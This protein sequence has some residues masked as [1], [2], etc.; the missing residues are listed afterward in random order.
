MIDVVVTLA[1]DADSTNA[2]Q[3]DSLDLSDLELTVTQN[4][5]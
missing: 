4:P 1:F 5:R 3:L 2:T